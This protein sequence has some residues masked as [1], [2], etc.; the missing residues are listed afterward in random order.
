MNITCAGDSKLACQ[1]QE[2]HQEEGESP[3]LLFASKKLANSKGSQELYA[4]LEL[5]V[6]GTDLEP[7]GQVSYSFDAPS[8]L[9][10]L[11]P[12][13][14]ESARAHMVLPSIIN[15][16]YYKVQKTWVQEKMKACHSNSCTAMVSKK[17]VEKKLSTLLASQDLG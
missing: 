1:D 14:F 10:R 9:T 4:L 15:M 17:Q 16:E 6:N 7:C 2:G 8:V 13:V 3:E 5:L 11:S 12:T